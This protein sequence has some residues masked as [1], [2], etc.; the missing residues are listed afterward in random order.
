MMERY[1]K[2]VQP[3]ITIEKIEA[4]VAFF[5]SP[6]ERALESAKKFS[7]Y[8]KVTKQREIVTYK[9]ET[10]GRNVCVT[11]TGLGY[12]SAAIVV[13][14]LA[15]CGVYSPIIF[16]YIKTFT[17]PLHTATFHTSHH[18]NI[19]AAIPTLTSTGNLPQKASSGV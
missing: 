11:S 17:T 9:C 12:P 1:F 15:N 3:H 8:E 7:S 2:G 6:P 4:E 16:D 5:P 19:L 18:P 14:E 10:E 13:E